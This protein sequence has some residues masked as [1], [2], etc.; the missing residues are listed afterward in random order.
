MEEVAIGQPCAVD[1]LRA[2]GLAYVRF[3]VQT[4]E[5]YRLATM[6]EWRRGSSVDMALE[7]SAFK[8]MCASA[9]TLMDEGVYRT[10]TIRPPSQLE[11][12]TAAHGVAAIVIAKPPL[13][14]R[15]C[16]CFRR[17]GAGRRPVWSYGFGVGRPR[18]YFCAAVG[19][20]DGTPFIGG[21]I[22]GES[23]E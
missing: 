16:R 10:A 22:G 15:R 19:M 9:R 6:G 12:W 18:R 1:V 20:G 14:V 17:P 2:Q 5:L 8:H 21:H 3:A 13:A 7:S 11:L 4:P 23:R